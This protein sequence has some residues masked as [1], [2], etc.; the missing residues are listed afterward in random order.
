MENHPPSP[1]VGVKKE[2]MNSF[3]VEGLLETAFL[4]LYPSVR[5]RTR[6]E[7][8]YQKAPRAQCKPNPICICKWAE[9]FNFDM[10]PKFLIPSTMHTLR[11][12]FSP[13]LIPTPTFSP[14]FT[15]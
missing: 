10:C 14:P 15:T 1:F 8:C 11:Q 4:F 6:R 7:P 9:L 3:L 2:G 12:R 13:T 5:P